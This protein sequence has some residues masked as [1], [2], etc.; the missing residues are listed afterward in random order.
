LGEGGEECVHLGVL[1]VGNH[2]VEG[3]HGTLGLR[4][5]DWGDDW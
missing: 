3:R 2:Q 1:L 4:F 5:G